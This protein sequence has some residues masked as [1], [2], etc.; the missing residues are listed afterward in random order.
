LEDESAS[1]SKETILDLTGKT[2][3]ELVREIRHHSE[4]HTDMES[5]PDFLRSCSKYKDEREQYKKRRVEFYTVSEPVYGNVTETRTITD[6]A[7]N[8]STLKREVEVVVPVITGYRNV[9]LNTTVEYYDTTLRQDVELC[10]EFGSALRTDEYVNLLGL[11]IQEQ[12]ETIQDLIV[13]VDALEQ[14]R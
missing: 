5:L 14:S 4:D 8:G 6:L 11:A 3:L 12:D 1:F 13:R 7:E 9:T 10:E 2:P